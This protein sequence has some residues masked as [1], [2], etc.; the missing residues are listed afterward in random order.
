[1]KINK[2]LV[3]AGLLSSIGFQIVYMFSQNNSFLLFAIIML[4]VAI[5]NSQLVLSEK[6]NKKQDEPQDPPQRNL[7]GEP[8][9]K[10]VRELP[11]AKGTLQS[12]CEIE[13][14]ARGYLEKE[15]TNGMYLV[16]TRLNNLR[17]TLE[18][19]VE[20]NERNAPKK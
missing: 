12:V 15:Q 14:L 3:D 20:M 18:M 4:C 1:M 7:Q 11:S 13:D 6:V 19:Q 10:G 17:R 5:F 9:A 2:F 16:V 8:I